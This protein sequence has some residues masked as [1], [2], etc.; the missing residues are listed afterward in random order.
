MLNI[1]FKTINSRSPKIIL[2]ALCLLAS[3]ISARADT[4][5]IL[6]IGNSFS[7]DAVEQN[8]R[9]ICASQGIG[10]EIG[11]LF[12]PA[13]TL[14]IHYDNLVKNNHTYSYRRITSEG[15]KTV[16]ENVSLES[17]L[18][19]EEW[20]YISFQQGSKDSGIFSTFTV[21]GD[22]LRRVRIIVGHRPVFCWHST[23][24]YAPSSTH[25]GFEA[26]G[27]NELQMYHDIIST[28]RKVLRKFPQIKILIPSGT[29]VQNARTAIVAGRDLTR[30]GYHL[31]LTVGRYVAACT[32]YEALFHGQ[33]NENVFCP[34]TVTPQV[35]AL[36]REAAIEAVRN[37]FSITPL[38][39]EGG[40]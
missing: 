4:I 40:F 32:W 30:D 9:E 22:L 15:K 36:A 35:G 17:V 25:A 37:P 11:N 21:L 5:R 1:I 33:F 3:I 8:L 27:R 31:E 28:T 26:Y 39:V 10:V 23:W 34:K 29:A 7:E 38:P 13:C 19:S 20:D 16:Q 24:A 14:D 12:I 2:L 6:A 18:K